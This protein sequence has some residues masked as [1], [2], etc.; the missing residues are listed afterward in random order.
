MYTLFRVGDKEYRLKLTTT[1]IMR[2]EKVTGHHPL[3]ILTG[4]IDD[5]PSV[6]NMVQVL[7]CSMV[8]LNHGISMSD[9]YHI[10]DA[11]LDEGH[12]TS[13]FLEIMIEI[14]EVSGLLPRTTEKN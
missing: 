12:T 7:Y 14:Y 13:D 10:F 6:T 11:W 9:V 8:E 1:Q 4:A 3:A 5:I 2:L